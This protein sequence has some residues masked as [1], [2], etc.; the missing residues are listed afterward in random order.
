MD[1]DKNNECKGRIC[2]DGE[3]FDLTKMKGRGN[4]SWDD[5][6]DKKPYNITL[7][8]KTDLGIDVEPTK[9]WSILAEITDHSL[10]CNRIGLA[11][12]HALGVSNDATSADVWMNGEYQGCYTVTPKSDSFVTKNGFLI[13][14]DN[15]M[16]SAVAE[17]GDPQFQLDGLKEA[18][19]IDAWQ[20]SGYNRI[21]VNA[22]E[23]RLDLV[24]NL[25]GCNKTGK[26]YSRLGIVVGVKRDIL[27]NSTVNV[28]LAKR[29]SVCFKTFRKACSVLVA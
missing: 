10:M 9:K 8:K 25:I 29:H 27:T 28:Y 18:D 2:I 20:G 3:W 11:M 19:D 1:S 16:E 6:V 23:H 26:A 12:G 22:V 21:T 14:Q 24:N 17:G 7:G 13:E 15:Y 5:A 4:V